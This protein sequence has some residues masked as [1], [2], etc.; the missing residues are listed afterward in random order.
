MP[1]DSAASGISLETV[2]G[3]GSRSSKGKKGG[4]TEGSQGSFKDW[5][6]PS[7]FLS[8]APTLLDFPPTPTQLFLSCLFGFP[9]LSYTR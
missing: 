3:E 4:S 9:S 2:V 5:D 1:A 8:S 6:V 7:S